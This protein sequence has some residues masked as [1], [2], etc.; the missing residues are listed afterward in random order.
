MRCTTTVRDTLRTLQPQTD[1]LQQRNTGL[2]PTNSV[3]VVSLGL[4]T[5]TH[6]SLSLAVQG[7]ALVGGKSF[8][9]RRL[10]FGGDGAD[11]QVLLGSPRSNKLQSSPLSCSTTGSPPLKSLSMPTK[12]QRSAK[13]DCW[14]GVGCLWSNP[15]AS[16][17]CSR[18]EKGWAFYP[19]R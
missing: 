7:Y 11:P 5:R 1:I 12:R 16:L 8:S 4:T 18:Q 19:T 3:Q 17:L 15:L 9:S 10:T 14:R 13:F 6:S 2:T